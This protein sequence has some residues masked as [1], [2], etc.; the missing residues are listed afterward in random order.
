MILQGQKKRILKEI[1]RYYVNTT[2]RKYTD[3]ITDIEES[4]DKPLNTLTYPEWLANQAYKELKKH[5]I[6]VSDIIENKD[7]INS[8]INADSSREEGE[9][10]TPE[11][12]C[13]DGREYL[14][15]M[16]GDLWSKAYIWDASCG[17]GNLMRTAGYPEDKLFLSS[18]LAE[19]IELVKQTYPGATCFQ[20]DF[21]NKID[22]DDFNM[23]FSEQLP[24]KLR[25]VLENNEPI[26]F[27]MNPP[28]KV[29]KAER[30]DVGAYMSDN[31]MKKSALDLFHQFMYRMVMLKRFYSLTNVYMGIFGP[32]TMFHSEMIEPL[33][34]EF[35]SEFKFN[36][37][38][39]FDAADFSGT[40]ESVGW[41]V[42][43]TTWRVKQEG[44]EDKAIVL[45]AKSVDENDT[46]IIVGQRLITQ[47]DV[48]LHNWVEPQDVT[49]IDVSMPYVTSYN[50]FSRKQE[51][52]PKEAMAFIMSSNYVIRA[53]RRSC[54]TS[55]PTPDTIPVTP[56]NFERCLA[57]Y[58]ARRLYASKQSAFNS[59][60]YYSAPNIEVEGYREFLAN[61]LPIYLFDTSTQLASYRNVQTVNQDKTPDPTNINNGWT[62]NN[63]M[64]PIASELLE[65]VVTD[66][67]LLED[68]KNHPV[69]NSFILQKIEE[70][71]PY[72]YEE[73]QDLFAF[74]IEVILT[75]LSGDIRSKFD[76]Q[77][78]LSAWDAGFIQIRDV[79]GLLT[80]EQQ[81]RYTYLLSRLKH[82]LYDD[83]YKYGFLMDTA[84]EVPDD[85]EED[86]ETDE[87]LVETI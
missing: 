77:N 49:L 85:G 23:G 38:M 41:I 52:T 11:I 48:N 46:P 60:Q 80:S 4:M 32:I 43:Y 74:G 20:L 51:R 79:E 44:E 29:G 66:P 28:Y 27:Y 35:K 59:C 73:A 45:T 12:W 64:F 57:S 9:F 13:V 14:K 7:V 53:T 36:G 50:N 86:E 26:V 84:F 55:L 2:Q 5:E 63:K 82:R 62:S 25:E 67:V 56:E 1:V 70:Y 40:S 69:D 3:F 61:T 72:W 21:L 78:N 22:Y 47:I 83:I 39:C 33:Y 54:V 75:S 31:G 42:G 37:G 10:Y 24:P 6:T 18:L 76:Y 71:K 16:L 58:V 17:S 81:E 65:G 87:E 68:M 19:D 30:T 34:N 8:A 15:D